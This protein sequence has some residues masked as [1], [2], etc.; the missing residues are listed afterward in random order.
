MDKR[1]KFSIG[2]E[3]N[4]QV[5]HGVE[6]PEPEVIEI[7]EP[8]GVGSIFSTTEYDSAIVVNGDGGFRESNSAISITQSRETDQTVL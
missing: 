4:R 8:K 6:L 7:Y 1:Y 2:S 5:G 3:F